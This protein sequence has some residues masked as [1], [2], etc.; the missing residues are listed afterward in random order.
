VNKGS[1]ATTVS[2]SLTS[3]RTERPDETNGE[4][5]ATA[6]SRVSRHKSV[7]LT[8]AGLLG[9]SR[10]RGLVALAVLT[11]GGF[12]LPLFLLIVFADGRSGSAVLGLMLGLIVDLLAVMLLMG[13][14]TYKMISRRQSGLMRSLRKVVTRTSNLERSLGELVTRTSN[15]ERSLGELVTRTSRLETSLGERSEAGGPQ[16]AARAATRADV[17]TAVREVG[18]RFQATQNLFALVPP[19]GLVPPMVGYVAAPDVLVL[20]VHKFLSLRPSLAIECGS[21]TSTLFLALAAQQYGVDCRLV[22]LEHDLAYAEATRTLVA[23][24]GVGHLVDIRHAPLTTTPL[25]DHSGPWYDPA[26]FEDLHDIGLAFVDGPP[27]DVGLQAR[28]PMV[29]L[30]ADRLGDTC[31]ILLDDT[32]RSDE[33][34][35]AERW[36]AQLADF[37]YRYLPLIRGVGIFTRGC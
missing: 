19:R 37:R 34:A 25:I 7:V 17:G 3:A 16:A 27:R 22:S 2:T 13:V 36:A 21:G 9:V 10:R 31:A 24:H 4:R 20:L 35:V 5:S 23:D 8:V 11:C 18:D 14:V 30:L 26:A 1:A 32:K 33:R 28:Y 29:P 12:L 15:L 6:L